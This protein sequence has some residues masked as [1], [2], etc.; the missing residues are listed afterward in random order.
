MSKICGNCIYWVASLTKG[1]CE[2]DMGEPYGIEMANYCP[3]YITYEQHRISE[4]ESQLEKANNR[5][6]E[7]EFMIDE[8][9]ISEKGKN[10]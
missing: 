2:K 9:R 4:L 5:I 1:G 6:M 7:L 8:L 3:H 10:E